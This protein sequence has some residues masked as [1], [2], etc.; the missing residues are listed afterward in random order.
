V[1]L[2]SATR[3]AFISLSCSAPAAAT[4]VSLLVQLSALKKT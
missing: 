2:D 1:A 3:W 4:F